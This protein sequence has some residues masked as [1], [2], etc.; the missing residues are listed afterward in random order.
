MPCPLETPGIK[1]LGH[2]AETGPMKHALSSL[3]ALAPGALAVAC[4]PSQGPPD[5]PPAATASAPA[6]TSSAAP[7]SAPAQV[8]CSLE[9]ARA[10]RRHPIMKAG[11]EEACSTQCAA[12]DQGSCVAL[13]LLLLE[14]KLIA[15]DSGRGV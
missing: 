8:R 3:V 15:E 7:T 9:I 10:H 5:T 6:P 13:A 11:D 1:K 12:G 2:A 4:G 14:G